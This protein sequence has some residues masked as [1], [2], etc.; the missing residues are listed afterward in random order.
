VSHRLGVGAVLILLAVTTGC[1]EQRQVAADGTVIENCGVQVRVDQPPRRAVALDQETTETLLA[2]GLRDSLIGTALK[3]G[4]VAEEYRSDYETIPLLNPRELTAEQLRVANPDFV[5]SAVTTEFTRDRVGPRD[6]LAALGVPSYVST[7]DCPKYHPDS[8]SFERLFLDYANYGRI[9]GVPDR[10]ADLIRE[11]REVIAQAERAG[12]TRTTRPTVAYLYSVYD[13]VVYVAG[14]T[15]I[16][17]DMSRVLGLT[18]VFEDLD[19]DWPETSWEQVAA[20]NPSVIVLADLPDRGKNG[21]TAE[22]KIRIMREHPVLKEMTAVREGRFITV[23]GLALD[24]TVR[25]VNAVKLIDDGL[26]RMG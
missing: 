11:Q 9:F 15:G 16:P 1:A 5:A 25:S 2:L 23:P 19:S 6:E 12:T 17:A 8:T 4:P 7:A 21:D 18:N 3:V 26:K 24:P 14:N 10:A 20:R 22:Q 13:G